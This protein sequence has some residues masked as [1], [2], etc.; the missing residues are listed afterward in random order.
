M[1]GILASS[2]WAAE[3]CRDL[4]VTIDLTQSQLEEFIHLQA[5]LNEK[6]H[7][8]VTEDFSNQADGVTDALSHGSAVKVL[9]AQKRLKAAVEEK[10]T[11]LQSAKSAYCLKCGPTI[12]AKEKGQFCGKCPSN[13]LCQAA[14]PAAK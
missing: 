10:Q 3:E 6:Y 8:Y 12:E 11:S 14:P 7:K 4:R 1:S 5:E 9:F 13:A 2:C